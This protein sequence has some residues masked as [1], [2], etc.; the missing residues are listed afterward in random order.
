MAKNPPYPKGK[1]KAEKVFKEYKAGELNIGKSE[2]KVTKKS[3]AVAI[4]LSEQRKAE[5]KKK[6]KKK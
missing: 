6:K 2:K 3:Q 4:A 5:K 1:A